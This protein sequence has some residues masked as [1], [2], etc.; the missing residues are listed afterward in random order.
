M[1]VVAELGDELHRELSAAYPAVAVS[2]LFKTRDPNRYP[3]TRTN[4]ALVGVYS[5]LPFEV[6]PDP[7]DL[8]DGLPGL[9]LR[10]Q[11]PGSAGAFVLYALHL[12]RVSPTDDGYAVGVTQQHQVAVAVHDA[13]TAETDPVV[14][15][16]DLNISDRQTL[17]R[18]FDH[19]YVDA[20][21]SGWAAPTLAKASRRWRALLLRID[22]LF[23]SPTLCSGD[24]ERFALP[25]S[26]HLAITVELG[27]CPR[28]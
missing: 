17:Y 22:H 28:S 7:T 6:L 1:V 18:V 2:E 13:T 5:D 10:V 11:R 25:G 4:R 26:D 3:G 23:H 14:V 20:M 19:D 12:P 27:R 9:R 15:A 8:A 21:R 16:G 24:A